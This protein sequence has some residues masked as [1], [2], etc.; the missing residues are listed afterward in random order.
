MGDIT[1]R[2][3]APLSDRLREVFHE[4]WKY[5][6]VSALSLGVDL[7]VFW[8]LV[9][10][11]GVHYLAAN[12]VSVSAGLVVNYALSVTLVF[13]ARRLKSRQAEFIGFVLI[14]LAGLAVNEALVAL[15][16]GGLGLG[17]L[18]G[19]VAA[20]GGSF[21]FNFGVRKALLFSAPR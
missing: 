17:T 8:T 6:L 15:F 13:K 11:I 5:F 18:L 7:G 19:K 21:V 14:G 4:S 1:T 20:A 9:N 10:K 3:T 16:V 12:I 2:E